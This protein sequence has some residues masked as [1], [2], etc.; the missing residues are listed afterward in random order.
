MTDVFANRYRV[1]GSLG[2]GGMGTVYRVVDQLQDDQEL[3][4]KMI[5]S[6]GNIG[7]EARLRFKEEFRAMAK[8]RHPNT[9]AVNDFGLLDA[10]THYLTMD[11]VPGND[12]S[13]L[14]QQSALPFPGIYHYL[15]QLLQALAFIHARLYVHRDIKSGNVRIM[16][17]GTLKIMDFGLMNQIGIISDG[18]LSGTVS[19]LPPEVMQGGVVD[20]RSDLYSVGCLAH[21]MI[22][23]QVPFVGAM[24][25]V[26]RAH[27]KTPPVP[28]RQLRDD[29]PERLEMIVLRLLAK[30]PRDRY[31]DASAVIADVADLAD[32]DI[33]RSVVELRKSYLVSGNLVARDREMAVLEGALSELDA[34]RGRSIFVNSPAGIGKSRLVHEFLLQAK[35]KDMTVLHAQCHD[36][37]MAAFEPLAA[38]LMPLWVATAAETR[39]R[40]GPPLVALFGESGPPASTPQPADLDHGPMFDALTTW[41]ALQAAQQSVI[42]AIDDVQWCDSQ[43]LA[44]LNHCIR[45]LQGHRVGIITTVRGDEVP[46]SNP[47]WFTVA[48]GLTLQLSLTAF[49][50]AQIVTLVQSMLRGVEVTP[51]MGAFLYETTSG[52]AFFLT[53]VLRY[54]IEEGSLCESDGVWRF[55]VDISRLDVPASV[56]ATVQRRLN[57]LGAGARELA[58]NAAVIGRS[59]E[60]EALLTVSCLDEETLFAG[61]DA[62]I[63]RQFLIKDEHHYTFPHDRVREVLYA[64]IPETDRRLMHQR[65]A[66]HLARDHADGSDRLTYELVSR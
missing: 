56:E 38:A 20:A 37:G 23:G 54:L 62:L 36:R 32:L 44:A 10:Q 49:D 16:G 47:L 33:G 18:K 29:V 52:N 2:Q 64:E 21:E 58:R 50:T 15:I 4:L 61:L 1:T 7:T 22:C 17:D 59:Q 5:R 46:L 65:C 8:L 51:A 12:L 43:S 35:L 40:F 27:L 57:Q 48:E 28:L 3:A 63:E 60:R 55:P 25:D 42:L 24:I 66:E 30:D 11:I 41:L 19:Y 9:V 39:L 13:D 53:E 34:G 31:P 6:D 45:Q 26:I 14:I